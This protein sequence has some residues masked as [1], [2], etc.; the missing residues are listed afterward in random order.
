MIVSEAL[1]R[2]KSIIIIKRKEKSAL[3]RCSVMYVVIAKKILSV[4]N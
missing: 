2:K 4:Q 1:K 3:K